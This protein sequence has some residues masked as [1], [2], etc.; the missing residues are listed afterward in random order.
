[1]ILS[2]KHK[3]FLHR[4]AFGP[5]I[6]DLR[7]DIDIADLMVGSSG[8]QSIDIVVRPQSKDVKT[9]AG[10]RKELIQAARKQVFALNAAWVHQL[11]SPDIRAREKLTFFWHDHF[12][13]RVRAPFLIQQQNNVLRDHAL[14]DF[15]SLLMS[16]SKDPAMLQFL[17]NQQNR[18][19]SP[20]ENFAREVLELF[21]LGHGY[22]NES[23]IRNAARAFTGWSFNV[24]TGSF[25]FRERAHDDGMKEF[26]GKRGTFSGED[27]I[28]I[29]LEDPR[30]AQFITEKLW[31]FYVGD[32]DATI[33]NSLSREFFNSNYNIG[34][35]L[36]VIFSSEWFYASQYRGNRIKSPVELIAGLMTQTGGTF[37][38]AQSSLYIQRALSQVLFFPPNVGGWPSGTSWID[39]SSLAFRL[40]LPALLLRNSE[41]DI[42][43]KDDG[44]VNNI[45]NEATSKKLDFR[46][47]WELIAHTFSRHNE[48]E[49]LDVLEYYLLARE[50][51]KAN[52]RIV[53]KFAGKGE[54]DTVF[55][56]KAF[57][58]FMSLPEY[59]LC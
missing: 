7:N 22:Y 46:V 44:D 37:Q 10:Q 50:T 30:T 54:N 3:H 34:Q 51:S 32:P 5:G 26:K 38:N 28:A 15:A 48:Q 19:N 6:A 35:L 12:A 33:I 25:D 40:A 20:N 2:E 42:D 29:I 9:D 11:V 56:K 49:T 58:A 17:N 23:D 52:K 18:K 8:K 39:S 27:I 41:T 59:Q 24:M 14:G 55:F 45:I 16:V 31:D 1:M 13:C 57:T 21:T 36:D 43:L 53:Q 47:D 4:A